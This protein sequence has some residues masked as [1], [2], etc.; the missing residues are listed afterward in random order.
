MMKQSGEAIVARFA[1]LD[2]FSGRPN[3]VWRLD[4]DA[5]GE[6][7]MATEGGGFSAPPDALGYRG[8]KIVESDAA[9]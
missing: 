1:M 4:S 5:L 7:E 2:V 8:I 3:P 6:I 9:T